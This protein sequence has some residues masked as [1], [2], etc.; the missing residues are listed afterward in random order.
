MAHSPQW[1]NRDC[2]G[3]SQACHG[4]TEI[5]ETAIGPHEYAQ[6]LSKRPVHGETAMRPMTMLPML[7][8]SAA[9]LP[10]TAHAVDLDNGESQYR[11]CKA[12]HDMGAGAANKVGPV[13]TDIVGRKA[14]AV[15][16]F[17]YSDN[18]KKLAADGLTWTEDNL[19]KYIEDPKA[20]VPAGTM[21]FAGLKDA[22][23]RADVIAYLKQAGK[24]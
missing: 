22:E 21:A 9:L 12:C 13:L 3:V 1:I 5:K 18:L 23:D 16:D 15:A 19:N 2:R 8:L 24:K 7:A 11:K 20:V 4:L 17:K 14:G 6:V 10:A